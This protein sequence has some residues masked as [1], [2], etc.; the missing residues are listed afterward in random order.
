M[1]TILSFVL[2]FAP[3]ALLVL[4]L[5][6][7]TRA[8]T[9]QAT[10][11]TQLLTLGRFLALVD[12]HHP[13]AKQ[14]AL[15]PA[16]AQAGLMRARGSFDPKLEAEWSQKNYDGKEYFGLLDAG[17]KIPLW[18]GEAKIAYSWAQGLY[19]NPEQ[20]VPAQ[21]LSVAGVQLPL[22]QGLLIDQRR[23]DLQRARIFLTAS[24]NEQRAVLNELYF[25]AAA[26]YWDWAGACSAVSLFENTVR[27]ARERLEAVR[28]S[29]LLGD[30][31]A[32]DTTEALLNLQDRLYQLNAAKLQRLNAALSLSVFLWNAD[33]QPLE[34][35]TSLSA[36]DPF[37]LPAEAVPFDSVETLVAGLGRAHPQLMEY[38]YKLQDLEV[39]RRLK[40]EKLKPKLDA[41]YNALAE[42]F[43]FAGG[44]E[45]YTPAI[46]Q[47]Y[48]WGIRFGIPLFL[49]AE[50][51][52][53]EMTRLKQRENELQ[54]VLKQRELE[55]KVRAAGLKIDTY[56]QQI[57]LYRATVENYRQLFEAERYRFS[58]G[59]SSLFL[60]NSRES[61][62][63][64]AQ[65]KLLELYIAYHQSR[66]TL[67]WAAGLGL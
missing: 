67:Q 17:L 42:A 7:W 19:L 51:G 12:E 36:P 44:N 2:R 39:E 1:Q 48:K 3:K 41:E 47:N 20:S 49:R 29:H 28:Q 37:V 38:V 46:A 18:I 45:P 40:A 55:A 61:K 16:R 43:R 5:L 54:L 21:G 32:I 60:V 56:V 66:A 62:L 8:A 33:E 14:A 24:E 25:Q 34:A 6:L 35:D 11:T 58:L 15:L 59:E 52:D 10:D 30:R 64:E 9:A 27:V 13:V 53:L 22:L 31:P 65:V 63:L 57:A 23:A 50:R 4:A 26:T